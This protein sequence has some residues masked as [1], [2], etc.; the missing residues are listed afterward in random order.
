[1]MAEDR[2][3]HW[4]ERHQRREAADKAAEPVLVRAVEGVPAGRVLDLAC[5]LGRNSAFLAERGWEVTAV[6][7]S[8]VA[9]ANVRDL[10]PLVLTVQADLER[11]EFPIGAD[12]YDLI[13][14]CCFLYRPLFPLIRQGV[15]AGGLFV[16]VLPLRDDNAE[17]PMSPAFL[18]EPG[19]LLSYFDTWHIQHWSEGPSGG[20]PSR[21]L[22]S[23][24]VARKPF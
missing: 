19:E 15:R 8:S 17:K 18:V 16:G 6:D 22:R 9:L 14:D 24:L 10:S 2:L 7:Y 21:R 1:M 20:D 12:D 23:E 4:N 3:H 5:G 13:I 11:D